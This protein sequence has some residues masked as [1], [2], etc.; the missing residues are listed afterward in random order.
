MRTPHGCS[1]HLQLCA[2]AQGRAPCRPHQGQRMLPGLPVLAP[3]SQVERLPPVLRPL[4]APRSSPPE[5]PRCSITQTQ[6]D[7]TP[8][9]AASVSGRVSATRKR[10]LLTAMKGPGQ[11]VPTGLLSCSRTTNRQR[12]S[13]SA[14]D[15]RATGQSDRRGERGHQM[16]ASHK[17]AYWPWAERR[18][19]REHTPTYRTSDGGSRVVP[20]QPAT[21]C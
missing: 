18:G 6:A 10:G 16:N 2:P 21:Q 20:Q 17:A 13:G 7:V 9:E 1:K 8:E 12:R 15:L 14:Q 19:R 5:S 11:Y 4:P 3:T